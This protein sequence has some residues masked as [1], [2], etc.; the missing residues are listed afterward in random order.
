VKNKTKMAAKAF[1]LV[2]TVFAGLLAMNSANA[3]VATKVTYAFINAIPNPVGVNQSVLLHIGIL[4]GLA[5][6]TDGW[7]NLTVTVKK[8]DGTTEILGPFR[9]DSTGGTGWIYI[10]KMAG[11]YYLQTHFPAQDYTW[12]PWAIGSPIPQG[13]TIHYLA[14]DSEILELIVQE[15]PIEYH[16]GFCFQPNTGLVQ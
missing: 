3:Q 11:I 15:E 13:G 9:T 2:L 14:S 16:P 6:T 5:K 4:E 10:P 12:P 8:P 7:E 1:A